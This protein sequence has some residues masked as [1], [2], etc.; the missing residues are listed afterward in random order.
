MNNLELNG[1]SQ[2]EIVK[3][4]Y[5]VCY[6][7][8]RYQ[9]KEPSHPLSGLFDSSINSDDDEVKEG[10]DK[11]VIRNPVFKG[12]PYRIL[13]RCGPLALVPC[14]LPPNPPVIFID[15]R[16]V[17][18]IEVSKGYFDMFWKSQG[19]SMDRIH[20]PNDDYTAPLAPL[21]QPV[22]IKYDVTGK[23]MF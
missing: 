4:M 1:I 19:I 8:I 13:E 2:G 10:E 17:S 6:E 20:P 9:K 12:I 16:L 5:I 14:F 15:L 21:G 7:E 22:A 18:C 3:G 23:Q 11:I